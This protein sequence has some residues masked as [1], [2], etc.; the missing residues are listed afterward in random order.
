MDL[1]QEMLES[2]DKGKRQL[3]D[4]EMDEVQVK[5]VKP[6]GLSDAASTLSSK[7]LLDFVSPSDLKKICLGLLEDQFVGP[8]LKEELEASADKILVHAKRAAIKERDGIIHEA[9]RAIDDLVEDALENRKGDAECD[10]W[11]GALLPFFPRVAALVGRGPC[12]EGPERAWEALLKITRLCTYQWDGGEVRAI[13]D[14]EEDCDK[15]H[16]AADTLMLSIC[17][18]Q[19]RHGKSQ[20]LIERRVEEIR[21]L[22]EQAAA[23]D[24]DFDCSSRYKQTL[25][26]LESVGARKV[27]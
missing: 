18:A 8:R 10:E 6:T 1:D 23:N 17:Q 9:K 3:H 26:F 21:H 7:E 12:V 24:E 22:Q 27:R 2:P 25:K 4:E 5:R 13:G 11:P 15:F 16:Q 20:W 19:H 14:G